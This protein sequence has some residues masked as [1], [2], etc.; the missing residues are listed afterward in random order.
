VNHV[1]TPIPTCTKVKGAYN[2]PC[3]A[4]HKLKKKTGQITD[5][6]ALLEGDPGIPRR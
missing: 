2:T 6:V 5:V 4:K 3:L 1:G